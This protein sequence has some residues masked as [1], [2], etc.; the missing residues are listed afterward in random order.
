MQFE[1]AVIQTIN[2]VFLTFLWT[3][4]PLALIE[5]RVFQKKK[6]KVHPAYHNNA[7]GFKPGSNSKKTD[8]HAADCSKAVCWGV[9]YLC[10]IFKLFIQQCGQKCPSL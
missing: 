1:A 9:K 7:N 4:S 6:S 3:K 2:K 8:K 5:K 10:E